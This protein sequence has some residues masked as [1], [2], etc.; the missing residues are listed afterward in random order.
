MIA[1]AA[2]QLDV[3][4]VYSFRWV[5]R[6]VDVRVLW[7]HDEPTIPAVDVLRALQQDT[8]TYATDPAASAGA[9]REQLAHCI[10]WDLEQLRLVAG[11]LG[12]D[13]A[14]AFID[15]AD[16]QARTVAYMEAAR[17]VPAGSNLITGP[18]SPGASLP[19]HTEDPWFSVAQA[20]AILNRDPAIDTNQ[21]TL[22]AWMHH[23]GWLDRP[24]NSWEPVRELIVLGYLTVVTR[25]VR[26][27][28]ELYPQVGITPLGL[29]KLHQRLGGEGALDLTRQ[30]L[31]LT[32][33][34][35]DD[36]S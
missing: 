16:Q 6:G 11:A 14:T 10:A 8:A 5:G 33:E 23:S 32:E 28:A 25:R 19:A 15:W 20:A 21:K 4:A 9:S 13:R 31:T 36:H 35:T 27:Q 22:F 2:E 34:G 7:L 1:V 29:Q 24:G 30:H 18:W 12:T 26:G 3:P 17:T